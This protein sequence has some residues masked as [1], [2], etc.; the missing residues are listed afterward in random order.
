MAYI[1]NVHNKT[2]LSATVTSFDTS[3]T[4]PTPII[5]DNS[6]PVSVSIT[7]NGGEIEVGFVGFQ[8]GA[9]SSLLAHG[10]SGIETTGAILFYRDG[11]LVCS[12]NFGIQ[13]NLS[14]HITT[15]PSNLKFVDRGA[16][17]GPHVYTAKISVDNND[18]AVVNI[19]LYAKQL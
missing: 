5:D 18:A 14:I 2:Q 12:Y 19:Q 6:N 10:V 1:D 13:T 16:S 11:T 9:A 3:S 7:G 15:F 17:I 4:S 8:N